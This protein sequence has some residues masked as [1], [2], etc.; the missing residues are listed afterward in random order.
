VVGAAI[1]SLSALSLDDEL[2]RRLFAVVL[3]G[4][5]VRMLLSTRPRRSDDEESAL[6]G[7]VTEQD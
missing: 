6:F 4:V 5:A 7:E 1:G 2:L 3:L